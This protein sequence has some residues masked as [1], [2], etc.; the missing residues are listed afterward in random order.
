VVGFY[1]IY[2]E[3]FELSTPQFFSNFALPAALEDQQSSKKV[4]ISLFNG[5]FSLKRIF[6][7]NFLHLN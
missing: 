6:S 2:K 7:T 4:S 1:Y 3:R 5:D